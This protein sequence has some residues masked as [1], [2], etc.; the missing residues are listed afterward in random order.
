MVW[1]EPETHVARQNWTSKWLWRSARNVIPKISEQHHE[2]K[3]YTPQ[4]NREAITV[5]D[6]PSEQDSI[7]RLL[8]LE[9]CIQFHL[10]DLIFT[11]I[12][13]VTEPRK[14]HLRWLLVNSCR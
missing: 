8:S 5:Q 1:L 13:K 4:Q 12:F 2:S 7:N 9:G 11:F 14:S 3:A 6:V 10:A